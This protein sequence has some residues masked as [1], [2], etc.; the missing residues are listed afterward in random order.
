MGAMEPLVGDRLS[1]LVLEQD[2]V[3]LTWTWAW[4]RMSNMGWMP[5]INICWWVVIML[6]GMVD[7]EWGRYV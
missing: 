7:F 6:V 3:T 1:Y 5:E 2:Y 4:A